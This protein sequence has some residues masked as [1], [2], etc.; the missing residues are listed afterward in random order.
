MNLD[1]GSCQNVA[2]GEASG[3]QFY[4]SVQNFSL[5]GPPTIHAP[6]YGYQP[7]YYNIASKAPL[8][9]TLPLE[10]K[11]IARIPL[12]RLYFV[13][14]PLSPTAAR[15]LLSYLYFHY[16]PLPYIKGKGG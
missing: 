5:V 8:S 7:L 3:T 10:R 2:S 13:Q 12:Q 14:L 15:D 4:S 11:V 6:A 1:I 16:P 9:M